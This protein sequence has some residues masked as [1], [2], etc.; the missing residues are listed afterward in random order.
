MS[1]LFPYDLILM[2]C[3]MP[4]MD[5][6]E[7]TRHIRARGGPHATTPIIALT[8]NAFESDRQA[9]L[10]AGMNDFLSKPITLAALRQTVSRWLI[11]RAPVEPTVRG[12]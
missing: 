10:R 9:C 4:E 7:A 12:A 1:A 2:D 11:R 5:G 8:A 3:Q 6:L